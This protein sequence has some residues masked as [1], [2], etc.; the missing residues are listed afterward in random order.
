[1]GERA[2]AYLRVA[3]DALPLD[4]ITEQMGVAPTESWRKGDAGRYASHR[5][6]G[7]CLHS[8]LPRENLR[9]DEH[10]EA[11][12]PLLEARAPAVRELGTRFNLYLECVGSFAKSSPGFFL[13]KDVVARIAALGLPID[14]DVYLDAESSGHEPDA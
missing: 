2:Y 5:D 3:G 1:M 6:S 7:W 9:I 14:Y 4:E 8:P 11:L 13:S 10:I 12:L